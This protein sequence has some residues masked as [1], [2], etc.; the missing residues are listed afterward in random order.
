MTPADPGETIMAPDRLSSL[1]YEMKAVARELESIHAATMTEIRETLF[2]KLSPADTTQLYE[3]ISNLL[4]K[5]QEKMIGE[6]SPTAKL[7]NEMVAVSQATAG[8]IEHS[9]DAARE[10]R[11][12]PSSN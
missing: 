11:E 12:R 7:L 4:Q 6:T 1:A 2:V 3:S 5:V 10:N 9:H 8:A